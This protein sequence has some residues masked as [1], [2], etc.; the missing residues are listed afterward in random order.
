MTGGPS[1]QWEIE[2]ASIDWMRRGGLY[3]TN[4][5]V[6]E[7][8]AKFICRHG[9]G[10]NGKDELCAPREFAKLRPLQTIFKTQW[11]P[12]F[13]QEMASPNFPEG[14]FWAATQPVRPARQ[15]FGA[16][17]HPDTVA[18][19]KADARYAGYQCAR[20]S[21]VWHRDLWALLGAVHREQLWASP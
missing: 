18:W 10:A 12:R 14:R 17:P 20:G 5:Q 13:I 3:W 16:H 9:C 21:L 2:A 6:A 4:G 7:F 15:H 8:F 1:A 19:A 11:Q